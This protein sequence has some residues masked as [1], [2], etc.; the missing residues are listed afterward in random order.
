MQKTTTALASP[1]R[2]RTPKHPAVT[3]PV[4]DDLTYAPAT[5]KALWLLTRAQRSLDDAFDAVLE[6]TGVTWT[7]YSVL[8][9]IATAKLPG[10]ISSAAVARRLKVAA[11]STQPIV[12]NLEEDGLLVRTPPGIGKGRVMFISLTPAGLECYNRARRLIKAFE[13]KL[14]VRLGE[15]QYEGLLAHLELLISELDRAAA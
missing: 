13:R 7:Q 11:Q 12:A 4:N 3:S 1:S 9:V 10:G 5:A 2:T 6:S 14:G 8:E 15:P